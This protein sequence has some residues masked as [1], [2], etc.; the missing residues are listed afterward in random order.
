MKQWQGLFNTWLDNKKEFE[1]VTHPAFL[2]QK[3]VRPIVCTCSYQ[4]LDQIIGFLLGIMATE[5][6][7]LSLIISTVNLHKS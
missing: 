2:L 3:K 7:H 1:S 4:L 6:Q 5:D